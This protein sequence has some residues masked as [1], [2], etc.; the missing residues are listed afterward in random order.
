MIHNGVLHPTPTQ[1]RILNLLSD[2]RRHLRNEIVEECLCDTLSARG[3]LNV[4][5]TGLRK[6]L[7]PRGEDIICELNNRRICYRHVR[8]LNGTNQ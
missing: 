7:H 1:Q 5:I 3:A 6:I 8:L 4:Q 2:G